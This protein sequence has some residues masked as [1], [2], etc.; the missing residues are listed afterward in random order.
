MCWPE[1]LQVGDGSWRSDPEGDGRQGS[2]CTDV[3][4]NLHGGRTGD[5]IQRNNQNRGPE[6]LSGRAETMPGTTSWI[7]PERELRWGR[8]NP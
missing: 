5:S 4:Q 3:S 7:E 6:G 8:L 1:V 2:P